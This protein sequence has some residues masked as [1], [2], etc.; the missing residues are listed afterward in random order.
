MFL[1]GRDSPSYVTRVG[2]GGQDCQVGRGGRG[3]RGHGLEVSRI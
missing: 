2:L 3:G 1:K